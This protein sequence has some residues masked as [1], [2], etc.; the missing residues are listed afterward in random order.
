LVWNVHD[1]TIA[2]SGTSS[3]DPTLNAG[4]RIINILSQQ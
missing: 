1:P 3:D 4:P 2:V